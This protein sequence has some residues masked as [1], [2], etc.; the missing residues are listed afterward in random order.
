[1]APQPEDSSRSTAP[2]T[3]FGRFV[4]AYRDGLTLAEAARRSGLAE[5]RWQEVESSGAEPTTLPPHTVAAMCVAVGADVATGLQLA[6]YDPRA[7]EYLLLSPP[8]LRHLSA[9]L[10]PRIANYR[11]IGDVLDSA[12][13]DPRAPIGAIFRETA[14]MNQQLA[15]DLTQDPPDDGRREFWAGYAAALRAL[16]EEQ[17]QMAHQESPSA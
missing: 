17:L 2:T 6:G 13:Q 8:G 9:R 16:A 3:P 7:Y 15:D 10:A 1:L 5:S 12:G 4:A 11:A 14:A